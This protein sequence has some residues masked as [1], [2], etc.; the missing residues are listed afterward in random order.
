M[1]V[2]LTQYVLLAYDVAPLLK[3]PARGRWTV[4]ESHLPINCLTV[5]P[6]LSYLATS[7]ESTNRQTASGYS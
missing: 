2:F 3:Y 6:L 5:Q 4:V 1:E 7:T